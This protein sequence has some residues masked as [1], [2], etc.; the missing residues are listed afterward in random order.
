LLGVDIKKLSNMAYASRD[1]VVNTAG[2]KLP[3]I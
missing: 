1:Y 2:F 3:T